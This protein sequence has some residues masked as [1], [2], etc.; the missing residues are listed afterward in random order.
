MS[1]IYTVTSLKKKLE[2]LEQLGLGDKKVVVSS[3]DEGNDYRCLPDQD[4]L[5]DK[6]GIEDYLGEYDEDYGYDSQCRCQ[7][8]PEEIVVL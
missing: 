2:E 8:P 4:V 7:L 6:S 1:D 3:D 5:Y